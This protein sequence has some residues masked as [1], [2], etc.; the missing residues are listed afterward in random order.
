MGKKSRKSYW[1]HCVQALKPRSTDLV[2]GAMTWRLE[3]KAELYQVT[4]MHHTRKGKLV[5]RGMV[6][7]AEGFKALIESS[8]ATLEDEGAL[9]AVIANMRLLSVLTEEGLGDVAVEL[10]A[11]IVPP[12][13]RHLFADLFGE[14]LI[15]GPTD[16]LSDFGKRCQAMA[17]LEEA[18]RLLGEAKD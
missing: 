2:D 12:R 15:D 6:L 13:R 18:K 16:D 14:T 5:E 7:D 1:R 3:G 10:L 8:L 17:H 11:A 4:G 9:K